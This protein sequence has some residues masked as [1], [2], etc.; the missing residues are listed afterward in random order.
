MIHYIVLVS[1]QTFNVWYHMFPVNHAKNRVFEDEQFVY[2]TLAVE[3]FSISIFKFI[4]D[5]SL[6]LMSLTLFCKLRKT[7]FFYYFF[8]F[9]S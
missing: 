2:T 8:F 1:I 4:E 7:K 3:H 9:T 6:C 5:T